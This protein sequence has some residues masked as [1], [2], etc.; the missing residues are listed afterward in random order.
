MT[1]LLIIGLTSSLIG[2]ALLTSNQE[3]GPKSELLS[4]DEQPGDEIAG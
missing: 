2:I 4:L 1:C 3:E